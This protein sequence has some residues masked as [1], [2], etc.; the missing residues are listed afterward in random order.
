MIM[1]YANVMTVSN[2]TFRHLLTQGSKEDKK[3]IVPKQSGAPLQLAELPF[4]KLEFALTDVSVQLPRHSRSDQ[5]LQLSL[6][7]VTLSN[8][9]SNLNLGLALR[10]LQI[11]SLNLPSHTQPRPPIMEVTSIEVAVSM[12]ETMEVNAEVKPINITLDSSQYVC[13]CAGQ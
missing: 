12:R 8:T 10:N 3:A 13:C 1:L 6:E 4:P 9:K 7:A 11:E 5:K 2:Y